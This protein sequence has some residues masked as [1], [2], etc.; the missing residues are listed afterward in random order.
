MNTYMYDHF[1]TKKQV[2]ILLEEFKF[3]EIPVVE[4]VLKCGDFGKGG[5]ADTR[6]IF[7][8]IISKLYN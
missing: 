3:I 6:D 1:L 4:K 2:K 5:I 7:N 8:T